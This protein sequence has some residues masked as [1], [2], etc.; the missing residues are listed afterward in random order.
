MIVPVA[1]IT[2][3]AVFVHP[4]QLKA[5]AVL[6]VVFGNHEADFE[7]LLPIGSAMRYAC[8]MAT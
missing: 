2:R 1:E 7:M 5:G 4:G 8:T 6:L 3:I